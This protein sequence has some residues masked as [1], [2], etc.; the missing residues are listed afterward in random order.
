MMFVLF[1]REKE[2]GSY[3]SF[4]SARTIANRLRGTER[5][6]RFMIRYGRQRWLA[7]LPPKGQ[8]RGNWHKQS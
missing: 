5:A 7:M 1:K 8:G 3:S 2:I 4:A 6:Q